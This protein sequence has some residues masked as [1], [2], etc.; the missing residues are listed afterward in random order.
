MPGP[1]NQHCTGLWGVWLEL[2]SHWV[3]HIH[4][5]NQEPETA[6]L[7]CLLLQDLCTDSAI[8]LQWAQAFLLLSLLKD[9]STFL[10]LEVDFSSWC[11]GGSQ[12]QGKDVQDLCVGFQCIEDCSYM[13][14][15]FSKPS[16]AVTMSTNY[17]S[18]LFN[19]SHGLSGAAV[20]LCECLT[21]AHTKT[22]LGCADV[23]TTS[24]FF[25]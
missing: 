24:T 2:L 4:Q 15:C 13:T 8:L 19:S 16:H 18:R 25:I 23:A 12:V 10:L 22:I 7:A 21:W 1:C 6:E 14:A 11:I 3:V 5:R 9:R 20:I 17:N